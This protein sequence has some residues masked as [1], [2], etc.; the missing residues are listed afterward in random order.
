LNF[1]KN[2]WFSTLEILGA[3]KQS[4]LAQ[5]DKDDNRIPKGGTPAWV[6]TNIHGGFNF[7][8]LNIYIGVQNIFNRDY[9]THGSGVNGVGRSVSAS[10]D[11]LF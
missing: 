10:V 6:I 1:T 8:H 4:R 7:S 11:W 2:N 9:R 5:G 3:T